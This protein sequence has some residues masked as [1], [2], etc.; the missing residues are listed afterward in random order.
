[1][2]CKAL[3]LMLLG[4]GALA[5]I[6]FA[7][8]AFAAGKE[9]DEHTFALYRISPGEEYGFEPVRLQIPPVIYR[10]GDVILAGER[11]RLVLVDL[12]G[13]G[14]FNDTSRVG[15]VKAG[16]DRAI[17]RRRGDVFILDPDPG[18]HQ[19]TLFDD[20]AEPKVYPMTELVSVNGSIYSFSA[21]P[22]GDRVTFEPLAD[23]VGF[24]ANPHECFSALVQGERGIIKIRGGGSRRSALPA[25]EWRLV[26]YVIAPGPEGDAGRGTNFFSQRYGTFLKASATGKSPWISVKEGKTAY[27]P[28]GP[29]LKLSVRRVGSLLR[30]RTAK[31]ELQITGVGGEKVTDLLVR[32][33][34][35]R[36]PALIIKKPDGEVVTRGRFHFG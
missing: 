23:P 6:V 34:K 27:L 11:R 28:F 29:P 24:V 31:L 30:K 33:R 18:M 1:M 20:L 21:S 17:N 9:K 19:M 32:G 3:H 25:G 16:S 12:N 13:N 7:T 2:R 22:A 26:S 8:S 5:M 4:A 36:D 15:E 35:P 14:R 10:E